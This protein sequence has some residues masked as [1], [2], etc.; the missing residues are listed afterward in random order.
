M[1][2]KRGPLWNFFHQGEKS[3]SSHYRAVC[4]GCIMK[5][6]PEGQACKTTPSVN[7]TKDAM[8]AHLIGA[9]KCPN[10]SKEARRVARQ[11]KGGNKYRVMMN[12]QMQRGYLHA[13][14]KRKKLTKVK[15][16]TQKT[17]NFR[18]GIAIPFSEEEK[19]AIKIQFGRATASANLPFLWVDDAEVIKLFLMFRSWAD[20][21]IPNRQELSDRILNKQYA[22]VESDLKK[23]LLLPN[24]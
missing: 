4:L 7:G 20:D 23:T 13:L 1:P 21:V 17:L 14:K 24:L 8:I 9:K 18:K 10:A 11:E 3:N 16:Y 15:N 22:V 19:A 5:N 12:L 2:P 6:R